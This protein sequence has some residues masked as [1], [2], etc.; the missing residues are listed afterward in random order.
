MTLITLFLLL[1]I[2]QIKHFIADYPLQTEYMLGKF[3]TGTNWILPMCAHVGV[4]GLFTFTICIF[5]IGFWLSLLLAFTDMFIHFIMDRIKASPD[6]LGRFKSLSASEFRNFIETEA[7]LNDKLSKILDSTSSTPEEALNVVHEKIEFI[8]SKNIKKINNTYFWWSLGF[9][10]MI[11]HLT[12]L[13][14]VYM[15]VTH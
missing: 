3:K 12:D 14:V 5:Y 7:I 8:A 11:H 13:F 15:I 9:D 2:F 1:A 10:Q 6:M 4:H